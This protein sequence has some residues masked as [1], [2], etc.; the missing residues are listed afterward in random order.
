MSTNRSI[1]ERVHRLWSGGPE[2]DVD[3]LYTEEFV[4]Y[5]PESSE[6]RF[7]YGRAGVLAALRR[8]RAGFP[9]WREDIQDLIEQD[10]RVVTRC[11]CRGTHLGSYSNL[12]PT[13]Q[14]IEVEE[15][16]IYHLR[17]G[18]ILHQ[19][20]RFDE[21]ARLNQLGRLRRRVPLRLV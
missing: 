10:D 16:S 3:L 5:L 14:E 15:I 19:W 2:R 11:R 12:E 18:Q 4:A 6:R 17:E 7:R 13:G 21:L 9:D 8:I 1:I 20:I